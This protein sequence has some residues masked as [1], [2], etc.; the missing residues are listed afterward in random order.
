MRLLVSLFA[1]CL[2]FATSALAA[3]PLAKGFYGSF[4]GT[5]LSE[6]QPNG[7]VM[8]VK[9]RDFDVTISP[10]GD[11]FTVAWNTTE[12]T[13]R[14]YNSSLEKEKASV[15][16]QP[17][18]RPGVFRSDLAADV[19]AGEP[20]YWAIVQGNSLMVYRLVTDDKGKFEIA[21]WTRTLVKG[22]KLQLEFHR[23]GTASPQRT[24][25]GLMSRAP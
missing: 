19:T 10:K 23:Y 24:V 14:P 18:S 1:A 4:S 12:Y 15:N 9:P 7:K 8:K 22:D 5:G 2:L 16:F 17:T 21:V 20:L 11:G 6:T 13:I 25:K 3:D